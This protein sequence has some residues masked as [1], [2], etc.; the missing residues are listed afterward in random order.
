M[1]VGSI[2]AAGK[3]DIKAIDHDFIQIIKTIC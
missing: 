3:A 1:K 2:N